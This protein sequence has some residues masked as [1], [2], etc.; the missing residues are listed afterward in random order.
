MFLYG[1]FEPDNEKRNVREIKFNFSKKE[2]RFTITKEHPLPDDMTKDL[3]LLGALLAHLS[4]IDFGY[5]ENQTYYEKEKH[6]LYILN[7][8]EKELVD[9]CILSVRTHISLE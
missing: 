8:N 7:R 3:S 5:L 2:I 6:D 9:L 4:T 1:F